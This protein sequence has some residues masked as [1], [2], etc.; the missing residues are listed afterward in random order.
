MNKLALLLILFFSFAFGVS[1]Q[2]TTVSG[3]ITDANGQPFAGGSYRIELNANGV[4]G[5][6]IW[7]GN[8]YTP[9]AF[10]GTLNGSGAFSGVSIPSSNYITGQSS[11]FT[12]W[13][14]TVCP[15]S[16]SPCYSTSF[17]VQGATQNVST[18]IFPPAIAVNW[19]DTNPVS[20]YTDAE[21]IG[22]PVG[23][24]YF[25]LGSNVY[26]ICT[27]SLP[28]TWE[29]SGGGGSGC[30]PGGSTYSILYN[31]GSGGCTGTGPGTQGQ[32]CISQPTGPCIFG[33][34]IV[35]GPTAI[36]SAPSATNPVFVATWDGTSIRV[37][38]TTNTTPG[39]S[40]Y[41]LE[42]R[43]IPS[44]TQTVSITGTLPPF[45][46][47]PTVLATQPTGTNLHM[48]C[49][50][51]CTGGG[52]GGGTSAADESTFTA[53]TTPLTP[54][55][56]IYNTGSINLT[57]GQ[58]GAVRLTADRRMMMD[59][60]DVGGAAIALG[61]TTSSASLPVV[62]ASDQAAVAVKQATA[63]NLNA[64]VVFPSAQ[65]V[66][67]TSTTIT[68]TVAVT[69]S[70][71]PWVSNITQIGG[72]SLSLGQQLAAASVPVVL[73]AAQISTLTPLS[74]V[75]VTQSTSPWIVAGGGTAG[76]PGTAVLTVQGISGG[77]AQPMSCATAAT[78]PVNASQVGGPWTQ[79]ITQ[80]NSVALGSPSNYGTSPGAVTVP[81][82]NA[83]VTNTVAVSAA[84][85][86]LPSNAA[87]ETGGNLATLAG[88]VSSSKYQE[89]L[90]QIGGTGVVANPCQT[91][92]PTFGSNSITSSTQIISGTS[93]KHTYICSWNDMSASAENYAV[94]EGTGSVCATST[95]TVAGLS[96]GT[97]AAGGWNV[98]ANGG[99]TFGN[100]GYAIAE[101]A[102]ATADNVCVLLSGSTQV[103]IGYS[104]V[105][106]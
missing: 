106:Q 95:A 66:S 33:D 60:E 20:A 64:T 101:A 57:S 82:V 14:F 104:Y 105:Q 4:Q 48:V 98:A 36:G 63:A 16:T 3:T 69:Q 67:L 103:N 78:C 77:T 15:A 74:T 19:V 43:N 55:G 28:C 61:S 41:A 102:N 80:W 83:F 6:Y 10:S 91:A 65:P 27:V 88:G 58:T 71:S 73:T 94:V 68:G 29:N 42:V 38:L 11:G 2:S 92:I 76:T 47:T 40:D 24:Q 25:N 52:G 18:S 70:T 17:T 26:R 21:V 9:A 32:I 97:T 79:N 89:N 34:P 37:P 5:P 31:N 50:S 39:S 85:L 56:G 46:S 72:A 13:R 53:G 35:S 90:A 45:A 84:S 44:G 81:G 22:T 7:N 54:I 8:P 62:I 75:A 87:I 49:D 59:L 23:G 51:G 12:M 93:A 1:A 30:S 96:G 99:R 100:G 86:P